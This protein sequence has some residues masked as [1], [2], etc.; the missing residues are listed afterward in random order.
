MQSSIIE[1]DLVNF[2]LQSQKSKNASIEFSVN[3]YVF[4]MGLLS[5]FGYFF[6]VIFGGIGLSCLPLDLI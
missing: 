6:F 2:K 4:L 3:F 1:L 5:F